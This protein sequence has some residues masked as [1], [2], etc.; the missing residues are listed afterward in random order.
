MKK[1]MT[2][3]FESYTVWQ[4]PGF[5]T[6]TVAYDHTSDYFF[7]GHT[8]TL[9]ILYLE[10]KNL[11]LPKIVQYYFILCIIYIIFMLLVA[12]VHYTSDV[13]AGFLFAGFFYEF[14]DRHLSFFDMIVNSPYKIFM[15]L[16]EK[17]QKEL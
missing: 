4:S 3:P 1:I 13:V 15:I 14:T 10:V 17:V 2:M 6:W 7:S 16:K 8:G 12:R 9:V 5:P 11:N